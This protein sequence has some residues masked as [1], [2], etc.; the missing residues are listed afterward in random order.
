MPELARGIAEG[1]S[2]ACGST[3]PPV[4]APA[5]ATCVTGMNPGRHGTFGFFP[6]DP[7][8]LTPRYVSSATLRVP[9]VWRRLSDAGRRVTVVN[10]PITYPPEPV[11]GEMI[12]GFLTPKGRRFAHPPELQA[13]LEAAGYRIAE[14]TPRQG[15]VTEGEA[16]R[17]LNELYDVTRR[18]TEVVLGLLEHGQPDFAMVVYMTPDHIQH[19]FYKYL[20][21]A[22]PHAST[23]EADRLR[24]LLHRCF[25]ALD[26]A[27][28]AY[29]RWVGDDGLLIAVSDHGFTALEARLNVNR[30]LADR[31][32]LRVRR[33]AL[34][35]YEGNRL[36]RTRLAARF[37]T[38]RDRWGGPRVFAETY[39]D[40]RRS[41]ALGGEP[42]EFAVYGLDGERALDSV[43]AEL[44]ELRDP[45]DGT[46]VVE[47][48]HRREDCYDG[49]W[50]SQAP[51]LLLQ[52]TGDRYGLA[53]RLWSR[54]PG[55]LRRVR[56][57]AGTHAREGVFVAVG[58]PVPSGRRVEATLRDVTPTVLYALGEPV[59]DDMDGRVLAEVFTDAVTAAHP[60]TRVASTHT[61]AAAAVD[62]YSEADVEEI[63]AR[64]ADLGYID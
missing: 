22:Q 21:P 34:A 3:I 45:V 13:D 30:W 57:P 64:L 2:G 61:G 60:V 38:L 50:V 41:D 25:S 16:R 42:I 8:T 4:T 26:D 11:N 58:A 44:L 49:P 39:V 59:P 14:T 32:Y 5:W 55:V 6:R 43:A 40:R 48:V 37:P 33:A 36:A 7:I 17:F 1:A 46:R 10:V 52:M 51:N 47:A 27:F 29:R 23:A 31:G 62:P 12:T 53:N 63:A 24:P 20:D 9:P 15:Q 35:W 56:G 28:G 18:R 19:H 54:S